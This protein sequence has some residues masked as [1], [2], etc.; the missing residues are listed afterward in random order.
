MK[1]TTSFLMKRFQVALPGSLLSKMK[2][3]AI[4]SGSSKVFTNTCY[5][6]MLCNLLFSIFFFAFFLFLLVSWSSL[7]LLPD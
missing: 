1:E 4:L 7:S 5:G 6:L 3:L 2:S